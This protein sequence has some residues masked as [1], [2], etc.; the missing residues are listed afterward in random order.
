MTLTF[1]AVVNTLKDIAA[2]EELTASYLLHDEL[3]LS[4]EARRASLQS[5]FGFI[6]ACAVCAPD[7]KNDLTLSNNPRQ[8][9]AEHC[10][11]WV[12]II[13]S[14]QEMALEGS[15]QLDDTLESIERCLK[16]LDLM[17]IVFGR[18]DE[19]LARFYILVARGNRTE[20]QQAAT[21]LFKYRVLI[22]GM[23]SGAVIDV[24]RWIE[25]PETCELWNICESNV[26]KTR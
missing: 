26:S 25:E 16:L 20:P 3:P 15:E 10:E 6:C 9:Y 14:P 24:L 2:R 5:K 21:E 13:T 17:G 1:R 8:E 23:A 22:Y 18:G 7:T 12:W 11:D 19:L 4:G